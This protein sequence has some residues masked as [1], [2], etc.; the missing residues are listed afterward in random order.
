MSNLFNKNILLG[1]SGSIAAYKS[2]ELVRRLQDCGANVRVIMTKS[3]MEFIT[4]LSM[5]ALSQNPVHTDLLD[6]SAESAMSH[7]SLARWAD[8]LVIAPASANLIERIT[9]GRADDLLATVCLATAAEV[10]LAPAMNKQMWLNTVTQRNISKLKQRGLLISLPSEGAQACGEFGPGRMAD[11]EDII[12]AAN[13][14]FDSSL[15]SGTC[16]LI[17]AGPTR[18]PLDPV[19]YVSNYSSGK[20]G[21]ALA[22]AAAKAGARVTLVAG[23]VSLE[24]PKRVERLDVETADQML[25]ACQSRIS[26]NN[27]FIACAAVADYRPARQI[28]QKLKKDTHTLTLEMIKNPDILRHMA[29]RS[30]IFAVGFAAETE[31]LMENAKKKL[32]CK[33][34]DLLVAN[35]VSDRS[36]GFESDFNEV[37][38]VWP[39]GEE[40]LPV[41]T[42][43]V[44][45]RKIIEQLAELYFEK[46]N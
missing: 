11:P 10:L 3:S 33:N 46:S 28:S 32:S 23:P 6:V 43:H 25:E 41:A 2:A 18:E 42:K 12:C 35:D 15:L 34:L 37:S 40:K 24:T 38:L 44:L 20:M 16:V 31:K 7:I 1:V 5:Q 45:A 17:T 39:G 8:L 27:I 30:D 13:S 9:N 29:D 22:A 4:P 36:I 19:R 21:F 14:L 26:S